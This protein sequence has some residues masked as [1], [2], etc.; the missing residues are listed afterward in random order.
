MSA[1]VPR[2]RA[3]RVVAV[4]YLAVVVVL[5]L[6]MAFW[7]VGA[8]PKSGPAVVG[9]V[10]GSVLTLPGLFALA[11]PLSELV[12]IG[13]GGYAALMVA[14]AVVNVAALTLASRAAHRAAR[15]LRGSRE[16]ARGHRA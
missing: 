2:T 5:A 12:E 1:L 8:D 14:G 15:R 9:Y 7:P 13:E 10:W 11:T 16:A 4:G 6:L 3:G